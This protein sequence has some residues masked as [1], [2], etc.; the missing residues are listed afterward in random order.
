MGDPSIILHTKW[1]GPKKLILNVFPNER[2]N[3]SRNLRC[4]FWS[5]VS[6]ICWR[7]FRCRRSRLLQ[8]L[9]Q[10]A[11][12][13]W[14]A[15]LLLWVVA[16]GENEFAIFAWEVDDIHR[17][18]ARSNSF[19]LILCRTRVAFDIRLKTNIISV[20]SISALDALRTG[21]QEFSCP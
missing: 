3:P 13:F 10:F 4:G 19:S 20:P 2:F 5:L 6:S 15:A 1:K 8:C 7:L 14:A 16:D 18:F 17:Q 21:K 11:K 12:Q 9:R